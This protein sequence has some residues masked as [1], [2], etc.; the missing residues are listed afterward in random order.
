MDDHASRLAAVIRNHFVDFFETPIDVSSLASQLG[1][2]SLQQ[3]HLL[4]SGRLVDKGG[5]LA[6][7][8]SSSLSWQEA[9]FTAAHEVAHVL[10]A[11]PHEDFIRFRFRPPP[12]P[13]EERFCDNFA[14]ALLLPVPWIVEGN[15]ENGG[16]LAVARLAARAGVSL[17]ETFLRCQSVMRWKSF[18]LGWTYVGSRWHLDRKVGIPPGSYSS[19]DSSSGTDNVLRSS[20][21]RRMGRTETSLPLLIDGSLESCWSEVVM[22][23]E[24]RVFA[25]VKHPILMPANGT[26]EATQA[27]YLNALARFGN[28]QGRHGDGGQ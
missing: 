26:K 15:I 1:V 5:Y 23:A 22:L 21:L 12:G 2:K 25:V 10:L 4:Q 16:F 28:G 8:V 20:G 7:E 13:D 24:Q 27:H 17:D 14:A 9:R 3:C 18:L 19:I 11:A 6:I